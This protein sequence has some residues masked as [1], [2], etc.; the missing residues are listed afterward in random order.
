MN[1]MEQLKKD[2][3]FRKENPELMAK[4]TNTLSYGVFYMHKLHEDIDRIQK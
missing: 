1:I 2:A 3:R 4:V